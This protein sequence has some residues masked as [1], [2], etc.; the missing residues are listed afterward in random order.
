M[1]L[2]REVLDKI[3]SQ[4]RIRVRYLP[5]LNLDSYFT[6]FKHKSQFQFDPNMLSNVLF[7][8]SQNGRW[9]CILVWF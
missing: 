3:C 4:L 2:L 8:V 6:P 7:Y 9:A 5:K 1:I